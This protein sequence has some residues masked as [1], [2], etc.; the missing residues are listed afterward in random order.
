M[1]GQQSAV[2]FA[3]AQPRSYYGHPTRSTCSWSPST[4]RRGVDEV[5]ADLGKVLGDR[6]VVL[7]GDD[8]GRAEFLDAVGA[9]IRLI[10]ISGSLGGIALFVAALVLAGMITLFVQQ[11]Q[12]EIA[13]LRAI[14]ARPG[15]CGS[16]WLARPSR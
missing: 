11:R 12:R 10:A 6:A 3:D 4:P 15:R 16:S 9:S 14:G 13:L 5:A 7:T 8:R 1:L 2:F